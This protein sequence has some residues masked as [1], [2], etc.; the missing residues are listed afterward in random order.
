[1]MHLIHPIVFEQLRAM[2]TEE[3]R[4]E[5]DRYRL[6]ALAERGRGR[7]PGAAGNLLARLRQLLARGRPT[8][9]TEQ[10]GV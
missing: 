8:A 9:G 5:A 1:M 6:A 7:G 4:S 2:R 3:L 10:E